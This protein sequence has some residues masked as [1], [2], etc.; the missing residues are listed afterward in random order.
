MKNW[1][2]MFLLSFVFCFCHVL[3]LCSFNSQLHS[4]LNV[5]GYHARGQEIEKYCPF[6]EPIRL[7]DSQ[8]TGRSRS[9]K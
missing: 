5:V 1:K 4:A 9:N 3:K 7:Q 2:V 6:P 8:D